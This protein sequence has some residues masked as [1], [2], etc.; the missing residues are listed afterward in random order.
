MTLVRKALVLSIASIAWFQ[1]ANALQIP[2][3][4]IDF[5]VT[6]E[7]L[8]PYQDTKS[9]ARLVEVPQDHFDPLNNKTWMQRYFVNDTFWAGPES[10]APV[11]LC[12]GGEGPPFD[13]SVLVSSD[14]C[15]N[16]VEWLEE[17]GALMF[18]LEH[19]YYGCGYTS[20]CPVE[21]LDSPESFRYLSSD[22]AL[23]DTALFHE[24]ASRQYKL[25]KAT[26][27]ITFGGSYPGMMASWA[28]SKFPHLFFGTVSSSAPVQAQLEM[29]EYMEV[30]SR[31]YANPVVGGSTA[32]RDQIAKGHAMVGES[33]QSKVGQMKLEK[34]FGL[35]DGFLAIKTNQQSFC[36]SGVAEFHFQDNNPA[37]T[38]PACNVES[39]CKMMLD[40]YSD[41]LAALLAVRRAQGETKNVLQDTEQVPSSPKSAFTTDDA[42]LWQTCTEFGFYQTC[43]IGT[44]CMFTQGLVTLE[45]QFQNCKKF[46]ITD[47]KALER[48]IDRT[49]TRFGGHLMN[50]D[51]V[52]WVNGDCD[53]WSALSVLHLS[54]SQKAHGQRAIVVSGA[55]HHAWTHAS[56]PTDQQTVVEARKQ[57]RAIVKGWLSG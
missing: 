6:G 12:V 20:S 47:M 14:H 19:R 9:G 46:G 34:M 36:G 42:W 54:A 51:R 29:T 22:Q 44:G 35:E 18:A 49:N 40:D 23:E 5:S 17:T 55:S 41:P 31:M 2:I 43:N 37:C 21:A 30:V 56:A 57:I 3:E 11:F 48:N 13:D 28:R 16:A 32:C 45:T 38:T 15:N 26:H 52:L 50:L 39:I 25:P 10:G 8:A 1:V 33:L 4:S 7:A 27:W 24:F 53:P